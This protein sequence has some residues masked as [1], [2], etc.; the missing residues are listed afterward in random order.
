M[1]NE[2]WS[3]W[4]YFHGSHQDWTNWK[5]RGILSRLGKSGDFTQNTGKLKKNP[6]KCREICQSEIVKTLQIWYHTLNLKKEL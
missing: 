2:L 5:S 1:P 4:T 3:M 6:G